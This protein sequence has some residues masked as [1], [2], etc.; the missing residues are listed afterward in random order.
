[1]AR[2]R[3]VYSLYGYVMDRPTWDQMYMTMCYLVSMRSKDRSTHAGT[4]IVAPDHT[5]RSIGYN[6]F[7]RGIEAEG[8]LGED[9]LPSRRSRIDG[10]KYKWTEHSER[11]AIYNA[12]RNGVSLIGCT[13][14]VN[15]LPCVDCARSIIQ[16]GIVKVVIHKQGQQAFDAC[17]S[18]TH[19]WT[20]S[21]DMVWQMMVEAGLTVQW[22]TKPLIET[23]TALFNGQELVFDEE[24]N[25]WWDGGLA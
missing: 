3:R 8:N 10:E 23:I 22:F 15:W 12:G 7:P 11:N 6:D 1:M 20:D 18:A 5:I 24:G 14:Y 19:T 9:D 16:A 17:S 21:H 25:T 2:R 13:L 4:V